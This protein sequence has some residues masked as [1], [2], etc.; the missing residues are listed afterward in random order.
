M[1]HFEKYRITREVLK[2]IGTLDIF[3]PYFCQLT[4]DREASEK[5]L[6]ALNALSSFFNQMKDGLAAQVEDAE[7]RGMKTLAGLCGYYG[8]HI[9]EAI[10]YEEAKLNREIQSYESTLKDLVEN[11]GYTLEMAEKVLADTKPDPDLHAQKIAV[12]CEERGKIEKFTR[13]FPR[14][15]MALLDGTRFEGWTVENNQFLDPCNPVYEHG[16]PKVTR[17]DEIETDAYGLLGRAGLK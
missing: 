17:W 8:L 14:F 4:D 3:K 6:E 9:G 11:R 2:T 5:A 10:A 13:D 7:L 12:L 16:R 1:N 15:D